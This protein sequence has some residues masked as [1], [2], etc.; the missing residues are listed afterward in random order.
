MGGESQIHST[1]MPFE[2][3]LVDDNAGDVRLLQEAFR[4]V[5]DSLHVHVASMALRQ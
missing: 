1:R 2:I 3:L 5:D 4:E